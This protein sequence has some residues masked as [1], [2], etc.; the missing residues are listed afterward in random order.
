M[1]AP[2]IVTDCVRAQRAQDPPSPDNLCRTNQPAP[3]AKKEAQTEIIPRCYNRFI[4]H[5]P[6]HGPHG[7]TLSRAKQ[8]PDAFSIARNIPI[9]SM[10]VPVCASEPLRREHTENG[11]P[12]PSIFEIFHIDTWCM[13]H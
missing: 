11:A 3:L 1:L 8:T 4:G 9:C 10:Q 12:R 7:A 5:P 13:F 6:Q 2:L